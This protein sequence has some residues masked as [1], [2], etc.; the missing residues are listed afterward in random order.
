MTPTHWPCHD[1]CCRV[2]LS[3]I[4]SAVLRSLFYLASE[5]VRIEV[6]AETRDLAVSHLQDAH[7]FICYWSTRG[8]R[9]GRRPLECRPAIA[10]DDIAEGRG[11]LPERIPVRLPE[12]VSAFQTNELPGGDDVADLAVLHEETKHF[13]RVAVTLQDL[14]RFDELL[15]CFRFGHCWVLRFHCWFL[16]RM[17]IR[18]QSAVRSVAKRR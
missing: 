4:G 16:R 5:F 14:Q 6:G 7:T 12:L 15:S 9:P 17:L 8:T 2:S 10:D 11:H 13:S 18:G 1:G 3:C